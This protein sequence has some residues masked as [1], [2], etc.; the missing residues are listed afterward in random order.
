M[1]P[2]EYQDLAALTESPV[3]S[4]T[5]RRQIAASGAMIQMMKRCRAAL[6]PADQHKRFIFYDDPGNLDGPFIDSARTEVRFIHGILGLLSEMDE[7]L[8]IVQTE[9]VID[10]THLKEEL[11]DLMWYI[12]LIASSQSITLQDIMESNIRKLAK[13]N[14]DKG[15]FDLA[16]TLERNLPIERMM[17]E[18]HRSVID[19][20]SNGMSGDL[21][22]NDARVIEPGVITY[23]PHSD[24]PQL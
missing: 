1:S 22:A 17:L 18:G 20:T 23:N 6:A 10:K 14:R 4:E 19:L 7:M 8:E 15:H 9:A 12:C 11:G 16:G 2:N 5:C 24:I 21:P 13:R 3:G